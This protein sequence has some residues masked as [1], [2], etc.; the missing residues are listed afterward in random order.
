MTHST[1]HKAFSP[2]SSTCASLVAIVT[3]TG[4][5]LSHTGKE[6]SSSNFAGIGD[7]GTG[8]FVE[9]DVLRLDVKVED[10]RPAVME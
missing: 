1:T 6:R 8:I 7:N 2:A 10:S 3:L 9:E 5:S 4:P